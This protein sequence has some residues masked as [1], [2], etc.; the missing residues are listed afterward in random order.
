MNRM[1]LTNAGAS[2]VVFA[3]IGWSYSSGPPVRHTGAPGDIRNACTACHIGTALNGGTGSVKIVL[4]NGPVYTPGVKQHIQIQVSDSGQRRWGFQ[5]SARLNSDLA[6]GQA[7]DLAST[8][9][10]TQVLCDNDAPKPCSNPKSVLFI[11]HVLAGTRQ[12]TPNGVTFEFDW[13]APATDAGKVTFYVA[14]NAANGNNNESGDHIYTASVELS[15]AGAPAPTPTP[16]PVTKYT[17][18]NLVSD[19]PG[20]ADQTD[21]NLVNPWGIALS[22][23]SPFWISNNRS[24]TS[25]VYNTAG[26]PFPTASPI[27]VTVATPKNASTPAA[28]TGQVFNSTSSFEL[29]AGKPA[30]FLFAAEEGTIS[31]WNSTVNANAVLMVDNSASGAV[32]KGLALGVTS[33]GPVL[34]A[35]NFSAGTI[36]VFDGAF[37]PVKLA[38]TF[39]DGNL[40]A[41][42]APFNIQRFGKK[43]FVTYAQQNDSKRRDVAG[44]GNGFVSIFDLDGNFVKRLVSNGPLNSPWGLAVTPGFFGDYSNVLLVGN[45]G[46]GAINAFDPITGDFLG[47]L[48]DSG[49]NPIAIEGLW[50]LQFGN[51]KNGGDALTLYF[52]AGISNGGSI[53]DHGLFGSIAVAN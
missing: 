4:P 51:S 24:G 28:A 14:A 52:T 6:N 1:A 39:S 34:Y 20:L 15:A 45:F 42:F 33:N 17:R 9:N 41:G 44:P 50:G 18:H 7:G 35:A 8:D 12:G 37:K 16:V 40:P 31:G 47:V 13:I 53:Q 3:T 32:Y 21:P 36:D 48:L 11:E 10:F 46:D 23:T 49:G 5:F 27:V 22:P 43:L 26:Q 30:T 25:T 2:L 29:A 38:G 19:V